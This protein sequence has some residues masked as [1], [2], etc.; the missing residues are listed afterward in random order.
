MDVREIETSLAAGAAELDIVLN[1]THLQGGKYTIAMDELATLRRQAAPPIT[2]KLI[3]ETSHLT[4]LE[5]VAAC[6]MAA[7]AQ[8]D[9]VKTSTGFDGHGAT[10]ADVRLMVACCEAL[11][12]SSLGQRKMRVK[13]SGGIRTLSDAL[14]MLQAGASRL[15]VSSG[16]AI[17]QEG[18]ESLAQ[19]KISPARM[20]VADAR[21]ATG[22]SDEY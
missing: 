1:R 12:S 15:G 19:G 16:V 10:E 7:A 2:L 13:A 18:R 22:S 3:L 20:K 14:V 21:Q 11:A 6:T 9:F 17:A 8:F 4:R 5:I